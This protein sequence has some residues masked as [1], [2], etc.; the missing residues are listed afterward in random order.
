MTNKNPLEGLVSVCCGAEHDINGDHSFLKEYI[1]G[2][3]SACGINV[4][5][6]I[7][8]NFVENNLDL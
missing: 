6:E 7:F 3:C 5:F 4:E 8:E 2:S 1:V